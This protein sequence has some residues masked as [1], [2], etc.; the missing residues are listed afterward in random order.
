MS[1]GIF[2]FIKEINRRLWQTYF[3]TKR[4][5]WQ[6]AC[7]VCNVVSIV[8]MHLIE[9]RNIGPKAEVLNRTTWRFRSG[10][11]F[12]R[13]E[14]STVAQDLEI[15]FASVGVAEKAQLHLESFCVFHEV[16]IL[17]W[18]ACHQVFEAF[19]LA[20]NLRPIL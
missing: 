18:V 16:A 11:A 20:W 3:R 9:R 8:S 14:R 17:E 6:H 5:K 15:N 10:F 1:R 2:E 12:H 13:E 4:C 19:T 7:T